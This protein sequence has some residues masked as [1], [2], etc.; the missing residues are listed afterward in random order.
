MNRLLLRVA[1]HVP[2]RVKHTLMLAAMALCRTERHTRD[3]DRL[4]AFVL[5]CASYVACQ[6]QRHWWTG[7]AAQWREGAERSPT[8]THRWFT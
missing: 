6:E 2:M 3:Y 7:L 8:T 4:V 1:D 5:D